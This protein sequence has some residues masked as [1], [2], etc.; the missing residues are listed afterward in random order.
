MNL[1]SWNY[2][3]LGNQTAV[4]VPSHLVREKA[5]KVLFLME[6]KLSGDEMWRIQ[7]D[8]PYRCMLAVPSVLRSGGLAFLWMEEVELHVQTYSPN[9]IGSLT[10]SDN[11]LWRFT[12]FYGRPEEQ[13][14]CESWTLLKQL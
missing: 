10:R 3:G 7:V 13:R 2:R 5:P 6:T 12:G 14:K 9:C 4:E 11:S 8:L 1:L